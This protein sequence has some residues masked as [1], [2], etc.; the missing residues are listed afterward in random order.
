MRSI[1]LTNWIDFKLLEIFVMKNTKSITSASLTPDSGTTPYVTAQEGNNGV[2]TY[3]SCP[4]EWLDKGPCIL[5]GGKTLT[6]TYQEQDFCSNDSHNIALYARDKRAEG[7]PTQ[8]FLISALRA[9]IGQLFS[10]GDSISMKRAKDLSVVLPATPDGTPDWGYMEAVMEEQISKTDS[11]LTSILGITKIPPRQIDTSSW[12]EFSLKDLGFE[13]YH[14]E[15]LNKDRRR[16]G[17][18]PFITAGK[19]NRGIAQY[20]STDR[21]LYRK[22][23]TVDMF[24]NCFFQ[25]DDCAGDDNV[26]FFVNDQL[27][28]EHKLFISC[29]INA[30][31]SL[32]YAYREQFRQPDADA[33][34]VKLPVDS[35]G[36]PD[37]DYMQSVVE[38]ELATADIKLDSLSRVVGEL[39]TAN[40]GNSR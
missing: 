35:S 15:R 29:V 38:R 3:V 13:N 9:S 33:L 34:K 39:S 25:I 14:G 40:L 10:W 28:D 36:C 24:G 1:D 26:Y 5:I 27:S 32:I 16:E 18:V 6:F 8:L 37:W 4:S 31:T 17:E 21:K 23:I 7:L 11:R 2:Q 30:E 12:G 20:I 22:A 19:T